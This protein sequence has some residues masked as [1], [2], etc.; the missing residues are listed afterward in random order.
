[1]DGSHFA[2]GEAAYAAG[3]FDLAAREYLT[4][5]EE[6]PSDGSRAYHQAGN[7]LVK[8]KRYPDA[9]AAYAKAVADPAY[10]NRSVVFGNLGAALSA[11][12]RPAEAIEAFESA[13]ADADYATP[14]KALQGRAGALFE[15]GRFE[16]AAGAYREAAW[17]DGNP[18]PGRALNNL[19]L[20]FMALGKPQ[21][22]V[23]AF[24][25]AVGVEGYGSKGKA[26]A[27][28]ALAYAEMGFFDEAVRE[29]ENARDHYG[30]V[31]S[32]D[33]AAMYEKAM[34]DA[35]ADVTTEV[36]PPPEPPEVETIEGWLTGEMPPL[37]ESPGEQAGDEPPELDEVDA[38]EARFFTM[39]EEEMRAEGR[40]AKKAA[41]K[42]ARTPA[43]IAAR[44]LLVIA[45]IAVVVGGAG[46]VIYFGYGY[47]TQEQ[48]VTG[49][50]Q[51]YRSGTPYTDFWVAVPQ[52]DVKQEMRQ[53]PA[54]FASFSI[55]GIDRSALK[56][57]ARVLVKL[58]T[59]S[60]L[61]YDV[62]LVREGVGWKVDGIRNTWT[63]TSS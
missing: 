30:Y 43:K 53:L 40:K 20:T 10:T 39:S 8:L 14:H 15:L 19:G 24:K 9:A 48:T 56:S 49:V 62:L 59:G 37:V 11:A 44:I 42:A 46:S 38:R 4:S 13:L 41:R 1:M 33:A 25:A 28:L 60:Q 55:Q 58:D 52:T 57:T 12:G 17:A 3:D 31:A 45:V 54:R 35:R 36:G 50:L 5:A 2:A 29:F 6:D 27:N 34:A 18:D 21:D 16:E 26:T 32:G 63:S 7:A 51:A 23:E 22:A 61:T 47:P